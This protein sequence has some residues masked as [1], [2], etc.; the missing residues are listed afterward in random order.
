MLLFLKIDIET[1][2][3]TLLTLSIVVYGQDIKHILFVK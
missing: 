1:E 3:K 2:Y